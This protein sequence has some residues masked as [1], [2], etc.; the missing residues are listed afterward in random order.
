MS[1]PQDT[2]QGEYEHSYK[3]YG[4]SKKEYYSHAFWVLVAFLGFMA[5]SIK[6]MGPF[7]HNVGSGLAATAGF[8]FGLWWLFQQFDKADPVEKKIA[9]QAEYDQL[10]NK[11]LEEVR[12]GRYLDK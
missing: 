5:V 4:I 1:L 12:S 11:L 9:K 10:R 2:I 3:P 6:L 7:M 8:C